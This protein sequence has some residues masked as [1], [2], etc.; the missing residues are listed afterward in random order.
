MPMHIKAIP[1][2]MRLMSPAL[3]ETLKFRFLK[4]I[5]ED[6]LILRMRALV[7][8][9]AGAF[10]GR[11][12]AHI[13]ESLFGDDDVEIVLRLVDVCAHRDDAGYACGVGFGWAG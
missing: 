12:A 9:Y 1:K 4:I 3:P 6:R 7:N 5:L 11:Q 13:C 10:S 2:Q 8:D